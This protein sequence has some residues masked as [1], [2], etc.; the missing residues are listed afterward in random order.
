MVSW[1]CKAPTE[2]SA[3][4]SQGWI[5]IA[6]VLSVF[7]YSFYLVLGEKIHSD[8][9]WASAASLAL[10]TLLLN[11]AA[12]HMMSPGVRRTVGAIHDNLWITF[13]LVYVGSE[14]SIYFFL[15]T[16]ITVGNGFYYGSKYLT[17]SGL[18]GAIGIAYFASHG[19]VSHLDWRIGL[20]LFLNHVFVTAYTG[21]LLKNL[22]TT[23]LELEN[24]GEKRCPDRYCQSHSVSGTP[25]TN[26]FQRTSVE[27]VHC[28]FVF[29]SGRF[30]TG[31]RLARPPC[32][33]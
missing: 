22:Q 4:L 33:R 14:S 16:F 17:L 10:S 18:M 7:V 21:I 24:D 28:L 11:L 31:Q 15:Y 27:P 8:F 6:L 30:Q 1:A 19:W 3:E 26:D 23:K 13:F 32:R 2:A 29:R 20:G 5:R 9:L 25:G 12:H